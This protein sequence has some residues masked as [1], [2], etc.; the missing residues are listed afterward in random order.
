MYKRFESNLCNE[1]VL[2]KRVHVGKETLLPLVEQTLHQVDGVETH[3]ETKILKF[4]P[5]RL[6]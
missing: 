3:L 5:D 1:M 4:F 6:I 2:L